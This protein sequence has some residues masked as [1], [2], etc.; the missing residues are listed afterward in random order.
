VIGYERATKHV[1]ELAGASHNCSRRPHASR[2]RGDGPVHITNEQYAPERARP[3]ARSVP[4][5]GLF[6]NNMW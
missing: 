4:R 2:T 5:A 1:H 6:Y 3:P